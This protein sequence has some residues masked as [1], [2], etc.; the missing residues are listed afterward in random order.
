[1][2]D[3]S[4]AAEACRPITHRPQECRLHIF[5]FCE[6]LAIYV[7]GGFMLITILRLENAEL[8]MLCDADVLK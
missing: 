7:L 8:L 1:M 3:Q 6:L 5:S 2:S 4:S